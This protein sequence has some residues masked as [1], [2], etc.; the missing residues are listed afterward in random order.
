MPFR[1]VHTA[2]IHL[3]SPLRSLAL[4]NPDLATLIGDATRRALTGIV[5][6]CL[7]ERVDALVIAGDLYDGDQTS[8]KTARF[9]AGQ[10]DRLNEAGLRVFI[11]RGNH[12]ALSRITRELALPP[13]VTVFGGRAGAVEFSVGGLDVV[14]HGLSFAQPKAPDSLL[15]RYRRPVADAVNIGV[16]HTSLDGAPG[17]DLYAPCAATDLHGWGFDYWALGHIHARSVPAGARCVVMP[18]MPQGRDINEAGVKSATLVTIADDRQITLEERPTAL[19]QFERAAVDLSGVEDWAGCVAAIGA[20]LATLRERVASE[21]LVARLDL[22]GTTPLAWRLRRDRDLLLG[23]AERQ[24]ERVGRAWIDRIELAVA[25]PAPAGR[26][27]PTPIDELRA[28]IHGDVARRPGLREAARELALELQ[29]DLPPDARGFA[30]EDEAMF[31]TIL[32]ALI[33]ESGEDVLARLD[34]A[35]GGMAE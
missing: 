28:L 35:G 1:F 5:D 13:N 14:A 17:H 21:H 9:L 24:A 26:A 2:D 22:R 19:A 11:A 25:A 16:M 3:D 4:R 8:M 10:L 20:A 15:A 34:G 32:D 33:V 31:E 30:G 6:L 12:D 7:T 23:E 29:K 18:G 27:A